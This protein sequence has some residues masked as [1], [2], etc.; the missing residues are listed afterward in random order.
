MRWSFMA[1]KIAWL[2]GEVADVN[3]DLPLIKFE[4]LRES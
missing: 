4:N 3:E 1:K 2:I